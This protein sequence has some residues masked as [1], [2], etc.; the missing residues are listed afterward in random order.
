M[1]P[2]P[3]TYAHLLVDE[4]ASWDA[5]HGD[6]TLADEAEALYR[7]LTQPDATDEWARIVARRRRMTPDMDLDG[8]REFLN[9]MRSG[10]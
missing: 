2:Y 7:R 3:Y 5:F 6:G 9:L 4:T 1:T 10:S 8:M